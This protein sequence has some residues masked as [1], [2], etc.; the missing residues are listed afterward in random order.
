MGYVGLALLARRAD[1]AAPSA[2]TPSAIRRNFFVGHFVTGLA[3]AYLAA[4]TCAA[5]EPD[6]L[7]IIKGAFLLVAMAATAI[8][9]SSLRGA[10]LATFVVPVAAYAAFGARLSEPL[11]MVMVALL[12]AALPFFSHV[13]RIKNRSALL[14]MASRSEMDALI[15]ELE[16]AKSMSDEARRRAEDANLAKSRFLATMSHELRTPLNAIL[17]F[18][19]VMAGEVLGPIN[20]PTYREYS[21]DIHQ[22]G[23]H[24]L[25]LIN[26]I[27]DLS[28]IEAGRYQLNEEPL[29]LLSVVE[30]CCHMMELKARNKDLRIIEQFEPAL[31]RL[32]G[33]ERAI[34]QI[35]LNLLSNAIKFSPTGSEIRVRVGWTAGGGSR[36][37]TR[38]PA[39]P[40][41]KSRSCCR[42]S[43]R[44][45]SPSRARNRAPAWACPSSRACL[46][47]MAA[48]SNC[49]RS[50]AKALRPSRSSPRPAFS[51]TCLRQRRAVLPAAAR[52]A[53]RGRHSRTDLCRR[54][55]QPRG[56]PGANRLAMIDAKAQQRPG[57][58]LCQQ[59]GVARLG[60]DVREHAM[61]ERCRID[62]V[63][64]GR[65]SCRGIAVEQHRD[66]FH[67]R[68]KDRS[69][70]RSEFAPTDPAQGFKRVLDVRAMQR[71]RTVDNIGLARLHRSVGTG[72]W[73]DPVGTLAAE[74]RRRK[75]SC[76]RGVGDAEVAN[77][78]Q[79][80]ATGNRLHAE[81]HGGGTTALV[82]R[83]LDGDVGGRQMQRQ[84]EHFQAKIVGEADLVDRSAA[85]G[86]Q[87]D[88]LGRGFHCPWRHA[89]RRDTVIAGKDRNHR[90]E[91]GGWCAARPARQ[92]GCDV[93][94]AAERAFRL[95]SLG[96]QRPHLARLGDIALGQMRKQVAEIVKGR[97][98]G[99]GC[100]LPFII[101]M[102]G[103]AASTAENNREMVLAT[104]DLTS[105]ESACNDAQATSSV[106]GAVYTSAQSISAWTT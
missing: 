45:R 38:V 16:T 55:D 28:R 78:E 21:H 71:Q 54:L 97:S 75:G 93:F 25:D 105:R 46:P 96:K 60:R 88:P 34:R 7:A 32:L 62:S 85:G 22:S 1:E 27:L 87:L 86:A 57:A 48:S 61:V 73:S 80:A 44:A 77:A 19:E 64:H 106:I 8:V 18:S 56:K 17:G 26:E 98:A 95:V 100:C 5:C 40:P 41:T 65:S 79:V 20:S 30:D 37:R 29:M 33:D 12:V 50:C 63:Q 69:G 92:P 84:V 9:A 72:T 74:Q 39:F 102:R 35:T 90:L 51:T 82:E 94:D 23:Q 81:G 42:R 52:S 24:L 13:A 91:H 58:E 3:W 4:M 2:M 36:S 67:A 53:D 49:A 104:R 89:L 10:L 11:G 70:N 47:C 83:R 103:I 14:L 31:P 76:D 43:A 59:A 99:H 6:L 101:I 68:R 66:L 15:A